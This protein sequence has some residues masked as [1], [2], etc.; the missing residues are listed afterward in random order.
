[1]TPAAGILTLALSTALSTTQST[2]D[3]ASLLARAVSQQSPG[4]V[5]VL[6]F[7]VALPKAC[8]A[9]SVSVDAPVR[10]SGI[11]GFSVE[12]RSAEGSCRARGWARLKVTRS[13]WVT[14][15]VVSSGQI[16]GGKVQLEERELTPSGE[17]MFGLPSKARARVTLGKGIVVEARHVSDGGPTPG[18]PVQVVV[19]V[20]AVRIEQAAVATACSPRRCARLANGVLVEGALIDG[21]IEVTR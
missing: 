16:L 1:M 6:D 3:V 12:G 14:T 10:S 2:A 13:V 9:N 17:P 11:V 5:G 18:Q 8:R 21:K 15:G 19:Q 20:G 7:H 4:R